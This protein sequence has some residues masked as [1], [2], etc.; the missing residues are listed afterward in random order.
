MAAGGPSCSRLSRGAAT[1]VRRAGH[2]TQQCAEVS[3]VVT[4]LT[5]EQADATRLLALLRGHWGIENRVHWV[6]DVLFDEDRSQVRS[7]AS[8]QS[9]KFAVSEL[10]V[11]QRRRSSPHGATSPSRCCVGRS[12]S[13]CR[14]RAAP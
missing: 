6:R 10:R 14:Q 1:R 5:P 7:L 8:S 11:K 2:V 3:D 4:S 13:P 9:R 12:V